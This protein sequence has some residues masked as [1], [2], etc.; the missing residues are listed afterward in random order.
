MTSGLTRRQRVSE[1][2]G[3][4]HGERSLEKLKENGVSELVCI[5]RKNKELVGMHN[6]PPS[7]SPVK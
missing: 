5:Y 7:R 2:R 1:K 3:S 6:V 4:V